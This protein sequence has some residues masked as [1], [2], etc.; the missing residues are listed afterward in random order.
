MELFQVRVR[1]L[2]QPGFS[3]N[4]GP[5]LGFKAP[6]DETPQNQDKASNHNTYIDRN[7]WANAVEE[8]PEY[9]TIIFSMLFSDRLSMLYA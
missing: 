3:L 9:E 8:R 1:V 4:P 2:L 5:S 7:F 6:N